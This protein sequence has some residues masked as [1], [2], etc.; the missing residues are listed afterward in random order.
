DADGFLQ[1]AVCTGRF[2]LDEYHRPASADDDYWSSLERLVF[3]HG[4][5]EMESTFAGQGDVG[6]YQI[7]IALASDIQSL[8]CFTRRAYVVASQLKQLGQRMQSVEVVFHH[9]HSPL[10]GHSWRAHRF[11]R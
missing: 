11:F 7:G 3:P 5:D 2:R 6:D 4:A 8:F 1:A 10:Y 9:Q